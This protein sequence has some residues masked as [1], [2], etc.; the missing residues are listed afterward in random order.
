[1]LYYNEKYSQGEWKKLGWHD[2]FDISN[3]IQDS[4]SSQNNNTIKM[5]IIKQIKYEI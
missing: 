2:L 3:H 1:M 5:T 4:F